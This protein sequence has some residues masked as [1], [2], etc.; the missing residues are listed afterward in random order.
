LVEAVQLLV[1]VQTKHTVIMAVPLH[2]TVQHLL[3]AEVAETVLVAVE[4]VAV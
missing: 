3:V 4:H 1:V 2:S